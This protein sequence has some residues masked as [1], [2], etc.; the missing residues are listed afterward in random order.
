MP[1]IQKFCYFLKKNQILEFQESM[2]PCLKYLIDCNVVSSPVTTY[3]MQRFS[4][5]KSVMRGHLVDITFLADAK[6]MTVSKLS[7]QFLAQSGHL[8]YY[9]LHL[10]NRLQNTSKKVEKNHSNKTLANI[11]SLFT[12]VPVC[13]RN[14]LFSGDSSV[15]KYLGL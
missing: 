14:D 5:M 10:A 13:M 6:W 7:A 2:H 1:K 11:L 12:C 8:K 4:D 9:L 15:L 3:W